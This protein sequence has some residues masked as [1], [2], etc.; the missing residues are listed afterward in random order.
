MNWGGIDQLV[1][2]NRT[3]SIIMTSGK[4][5]R[6]RLGQKRNNPFE[7]N[8]I[9]LAAQSVFGSSYPRL[10]ATHNYIKFSPTT[11]EH[12]AV[13]NE[14]AFTE[15]IALFDYPLDYEISTHGD[16]YIDPAV[17]DSVYTYQ[18]ASLEVG[19]TLPQVPNITI[20]QLYI[21]YNNP[22][23]LGHSFQML[24]YED[25]IREDVFFGG[26]KESEVGGLDSAMDPGMPNFIDCPPGCYPFLVENSENFP[27]V[28]EWICDCDY[29]PP[30]NEVVL[31]ECDCPIPSDPRLPAGCIQVEND[32]G[33]FEGVAG[34]RIKLKNNWHSSDVVF[35]DENGCWE[36]DE[37]YS[38]VISYQIQFESE[39]L[40]VR[41][42]GFWICINVVK[43]RKVFVDELPYND[44]LRQ[45]DNVTDNREW[46]CS[47]TMNSDFNYRLEAMIDRVP[48][49]R[50][51]LNYTLANV[52][53][54]A[55]AP[56]LQGNSYNSW[57]SFLAAFVFPGIYQ[58]SNQF[59]PDITN[60]Y[61]DMNVQE[62]WGTM[63][64]ELGHATHHEII[65]EGYWFG[66]R[67]HIVANSGYGTFPNFSGNNV[68][69]VAL[70]EAIGNYTGFMYGQTPAG[71]EN[72]DIDNQDLFIPLGLMNDLE[73]VA[74]DFVQD[75]ND[76]TQN[77][78][79]NVEGFTPE[80]IFN[81]LDTPDDIESYRVRLHELH[82]DDTANNL[83]DYIELFNVYDVFN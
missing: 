8:Q 21:N 75:P 13:L 6:L 25:A 12:L 49:P 60:P 38:D 33:R 52:D 69:K 71:G 64:H 4:F 23:L 26:I 1:A 46:A 2:E 83:N 80:M 39:S 70:G 11:Q 36:H 59:Q 53:T 40:K 61:A 68:G 31:N 65:G 24:G 50:T 37:R 28:L 18:Y 22:L 47:W 15:N 66:Y 63:H 55:S 35:A 41:D 29:E 48:L 20:S 67:N 54:R 77:V 32:N 19:I 81:A 57:L 62:L 10:Q 27:M 3:Q 30:V 7:I 45:Y 56:M 34:P 14:W 44:L 82:F 51:R 5:K 9:N 79:E 76:L 78:F 72:Q 42:V 16:Y 74:V 58:I 17:S 43:D 73:D